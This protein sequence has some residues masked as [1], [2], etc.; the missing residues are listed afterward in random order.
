[1]TFLLY[2]TAILL[3]LALAILIVWGFRAGGR[4]RSIAAVAA[5]VLLLGAFYMPTTSLM[6]AYTEYKA[7]EARNVEMQRQNPMAHWGNC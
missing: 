2:S 5:A 6:E 7:F 3:G 1:M 4:F